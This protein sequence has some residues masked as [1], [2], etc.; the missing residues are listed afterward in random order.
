MALR[1]IHKKILG[2]IVFCACLRL[3]ASVR[4][5][6]SPEKG[7]NHTGD[8]KMVPPYNKKD[9]FDLEEIDT[10][11]A[12]KDI[13]EIQAAR[14]AP[15]NNHDELFVKDEEA[16]DAGAG[17]GVG[18][19]AKAGAGAG[20][21]DEE[22]QQLQAP[23]DS[24]VKIPQL[25]ERFDNIDEKSK[26]ELVNSRIDQVEKKDKL[27]VNIENKIDGPEKIIDTQLEKDNIK[28]LQ[29]NLKSLVES[30][31]VKDVG[32]QQE[33]RKETKLKIMEPHSSKNKEAGRKKE[34]DGIRGG[35]EENQL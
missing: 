23:R 30:E 10:D 35:R 13:K 4:D 28:G 24:K 6:I 25:S 12:I 1:Q 17:A 2:F 34:V 15:K 16:A 27:D 29:D 31:P 22:N 18:A 9:A 33:K 26:E 5:R 21:N 20:T 7:D 11:K 14:E 8:R 19:E 3:F 32:V